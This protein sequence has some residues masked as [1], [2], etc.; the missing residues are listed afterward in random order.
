MSEALGM[1][2]TRGFIASVEAADA[3][4]KAAD[5]RLV[6]QE[7]ADAG[8]MTILVSGDVGAVQAALEAGQEAAK[9][10]GVLVA[11]HMIARPDDE[12]NQLLQKSELTAAASQQRGDTIKN[13]AGRKRAENKLNP[14]SDHTTGVE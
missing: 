4:I 10:V 7:S 11:A 3:M 14:E 12:V 8:L 13:H 2:E 9:R 1:I 5:V 6:R